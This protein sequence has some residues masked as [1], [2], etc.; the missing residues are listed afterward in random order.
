M[1]SYRTQGD[2]KIPVTVVS[3]SR[4]A[5]AQWRDSVP[6]VLLPDDI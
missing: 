4:G 6:V 5:S 1:T 3:F 2:S